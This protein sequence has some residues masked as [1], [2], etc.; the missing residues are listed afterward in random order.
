MIQRRVQKAFSGSAVRYDQNALLQR[1]VSRQLLAAAG[2]LPDDGAVLDIGMG[3][4]RMAA[5]LKCRRPRVHVVGV[6]LAFGMVAFARRW[7]RQVQAVQADA[8]RLPFKN[9]C[10][11]AVVSNLAFQWID[12]LSQAFYQINRVL[13]M[14]GPFL[15]TVFTRKTLWEL[16]QSL[17]ETARRPAGGRLISDSRLPDEREVF[18]ALEGTGFSIENKNRQENRQQYASLMALLRWLKATGANA[19]NS[20]IFV[21]P[22]WLQDAERYYHYNFQWH[23]GVQA[24]FEIMQVVARKR[25]SL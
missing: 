8:L 5:E 18:K 2:A 3:T 25:K 16:Y 15:L 10:F 21:G 22:Q 9:S 23:D 6:D 20:D 17:G 19:M 7:H 11:D 12:D 1:D 13:K 24:T 14:D 4:G